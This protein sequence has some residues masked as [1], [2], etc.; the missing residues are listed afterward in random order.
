[1]SVENRVFE[2]SADLMTEEDIPE[3]LEIEKESFLAPWSESMFVGE[4]N[5]S[6]S[7]CICARAKYNNESILAG[8]II[9]LMVSPVNS[10]A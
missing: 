10:F 1:M 3:I 7:Y 8:Y 2:V 6:M 9:F 5:N 4:I